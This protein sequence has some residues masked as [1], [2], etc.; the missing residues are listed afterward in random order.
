VDDYEERIECERTE[1]I[2]QKNRD[3]INAWA[4]REMR[5]VEDHAALHAEDSPIQNNFED[6]RR[7]LKAT[8]A[9]TVA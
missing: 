2:A 9:G 5:C 1:A 8:I 7:K 3:R 4:L 6:Q